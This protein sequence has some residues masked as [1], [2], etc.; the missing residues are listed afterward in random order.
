MHVLKTG[1][2]E[3]NKTVFDSDFKTWKYAVRG[4]TTDNLDLRVIIAFDDEGMLK[5]AAA[6]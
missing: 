4:Y 1:L 3:K 6:T 2:E 5:T